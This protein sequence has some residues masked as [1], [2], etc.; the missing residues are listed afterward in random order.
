[1]KKVIS[2]ILSLLISTIIASFSACADENNVSFTDEKS[3]ESIVEETIIPTEATE[4]N[5]TE[6]NATEENAPEVEVT[7]LPTAESIVAQEEDFFW[8]MKN[9]SEFAY[10]EKNDKIEY[11]PMIAS[12]AVAVA[13]QIYDGITYLPFRYV[14]EEILGFSDA[15]GKKET[16][17]NKEYMWSN[18]SS[19]N[20][21]FNVNGITRTITAGEIIDYND[22]EFDALKVSDSGVSYFPLRYF[23]KEKLCSLSW[24]NNTSSIIISSTK[25]YGEKYFS[26]INS[27]K[28]TNNYITYSDAVLND[29]NENTVI[30]LS[31]KVNEKVH[32][33]SN[34]Y[35][36]TFYSDA[37]QK[38]HYID[39]SDD[40][41]LSHN[42]DVYDVDGNKVD[43]KI[44]KM[45]VY[46]NMLYGLAIGEENEV[47]GYLFSANLST[48][49]FEDDNGVYTYKIKADNFRKI[50]ESNGIMMFDIEKNIRSLNI[51][52]VDSNA[53]YTLYK[54]N[55]QTGEVQTI[56]VD[57]SPLKNIDYFSIGKNS[58]AYNDWEKGT[59]KIASFDGNNI[60]NVID[61]ENVE[62]IR[63]ISYDDINDCFYYVTIVPDIQ[64]EIKK[65]SLSNTVPETL[66]CADKIRSLSV[67]EGSI[68]AK[69][70]DEFQKCN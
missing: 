14:F 32:S 15:T 45:T 62:K 70:N 64:N 29:D 53:E 40:N 30:S 7:P 5:A 43:V 47:S 24:D 26:K 44:D 12:N 61:S 41:N 3:S 9:E 67:F 46:Q 17:D 35:N 6:E 49:I 25:E 11:L 48:E 59:V 21:S 18:T 27:R 16:L 20:I 55:L 8:C 58:I 38:V 65:I 39:M 34:N 13:P 28:F 1:M 36:L 63:F 42:L 66:Y 37:N 68:Y 23:E 4:E 57:G 69:V 60:S 31:G 54:L 52:Y 50:T 10:I 22:S 2:I 33:A 56:D 19:F 51:Y